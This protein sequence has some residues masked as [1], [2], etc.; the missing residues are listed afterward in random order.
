[1]DR[2]KVVQRLVTVFR[3]YGYEGATLARIAQATGLGKASLYH[4]FPNG[5]QEMAEAVLQFVGQ[6]FENTI[7]APLHSSDQP[8]TRIQLMSEHLRQFYDRGRSACLLA[9]FTLGDADDL[10]H[11]QVHLMLRAWIDS[12][13]DLAMSIGVPAPE[14]L[15]RAEDAVMQVQGALVLTRTF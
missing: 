2:V 6:W 7:L 12:L 14:A 3:S 8:V 1:M 15:R 13:A 5:K 9:L 10:F 4:H 11:E